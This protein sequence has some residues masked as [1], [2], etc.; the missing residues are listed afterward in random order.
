VDVGVIDRF[1][2]TFSLYIE[3]GFGLLQG[4]VAYLTAIL[5]A[6]DLALVGLTWALSANGPEEVLMRLIKK[7]LYVGAFALIIGNFN[8]L[9]NIVFHSFAALGLTASGSGL[10]EADLLRPGQVASTG[11]DAARPLVTQM[12]RLVGPVD[13]FLNFDQILVLALAWFFV[14]LSFFVLSVQMFVTIL[15]FKLTT[16]AGFVLIPFALWGKTAFLAERVLGNVMSSGVKVLVLAVIVGIG[17]GIF[18]TFTAAPPEAF[19]MDDA[20][21]TMLGALALFGLGL[22]GPG[23]ATGLISGAPQL[24]AGAA[25]ATAVSATGITIAGATVAAGGARAVMG[26][27][28][29][30]VGAGAAGVRAFK[31]SAAASGAKGAAAVGPGIAGVM[32]ATGRGIADRVRARCHPD[33]AGSGAAATGS[34][35]AGPRSSFRSRI[36]GG[37][38]HSINAARS[39]DRGGSSPGPSLSKGD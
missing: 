10:T 6:I 39:A 15:E 7:T 8:A 4:D 14:I 2:D 5:I 30:A 37:A 26:G 3:S 24:S 35:G 9:S 12:S 25:G 16:L 29:S 17:T 31:E 27:A 19:T 20:L 22:F 38:M 13:F 21:A 1:L 32:R 33:T 23:I 34:A 11:L 36:M 18:A 28:R